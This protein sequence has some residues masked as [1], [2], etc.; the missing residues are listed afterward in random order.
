MP[1]GQRE[2]GG[3]GVEDATALGWAEGVALASGAAVGVAC[4]D[5]VGGADAAGSAD[6]EGGVTTG[7]GAPEHAAI[8]APTNEIAALS[9]ATWSPLFTMFSITRLL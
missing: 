7:S 4:A 6:G 3:G 8:A 5:C 1:A 2:G 9:F